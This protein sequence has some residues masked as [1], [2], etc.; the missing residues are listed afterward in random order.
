MLTAH[1]VL[2]NIPISCSNF[3][4]LNTHQERHGSHYMSD[5]SL[6]L[7]TRKYLLLKIKNSPKCLLLLLRVV[8]L[9][10]GTPISV[11]LPSF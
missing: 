9:A 8:F 6:E 7:D 3:L 11:V 2:T 4:D 10:L 5:V 1:R